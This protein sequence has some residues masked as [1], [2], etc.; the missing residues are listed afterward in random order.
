MLH[1]ISVF[2]S[3]MPVLYYNKITYLNRIDFSKHRFCKS[4]VLEWANDVTQHA[5]HDSLESIDKHDPESL[6][7]VDVVNGSNQRRYRDG[8]LHNLKR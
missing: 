3:I 4:F 6:S 5:L 2:L 1:N 8:K 7:S